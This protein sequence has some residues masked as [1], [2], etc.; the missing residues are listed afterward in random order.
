MC[1]LHRPIGFV[2]GLGRARL[3]GGLHPEQPCDQQAEHEESELARGA[4][5][6]RRRRRRRHRTPRVRDSRAGS[7]QR[8]RPRA[9]RSPFAGAP[10]CPCC[11]ARCGL[12]VRVSERQLHLRARC[13]GSPQPWPRVAPARVRVQTSTC[14]CPRARVRQRPWSRVLGQAAHGG[15]AQASGHWNCGHCRRPTSLSTLEYSSS[16]INELNVYYPAIS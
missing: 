15:G 2:W 4:R 5:H 14:P 10:R 11:L 6:C 13:C 7:R 1:A 8:S 3:R 9:P 16:V 12:P